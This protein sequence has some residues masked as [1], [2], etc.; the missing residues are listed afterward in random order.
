MCERCFF[1]FA[2][3]LIKIKFIEI[4]HKDTNAFGH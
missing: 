1:I 3:R 2:L 4:H